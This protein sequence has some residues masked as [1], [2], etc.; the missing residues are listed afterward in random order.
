MPHD[1]RNHHVVPRVQPRLVV[2]TGCGNPASSALHDQGEQV[3]EDEDPGVESRAEDAVL[4]AAFNDDVFQSQIDACGDESGCDDEA[5]DL[6]LEAVTGPRVGVHHDAAD[7]ADCFGEGAEGECDAEGPCFVADALDEVDEAA[8]GE[9]C[10][11]EGVGG[12]RGRVAVDGLV[13]GTIRGDIGAV[14][15][16]ET[17]GRED[18][19]VCGVGLG[20]LWHFGGEMWN[21]V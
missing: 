7:V 12:E 3:A 9:D 1:T 15:G 13:D 10:A 17:G 11:V 4:R 5:A 2:L 6:R 18:A 21:V 19:T 14:C 16:G 8:D 20:S